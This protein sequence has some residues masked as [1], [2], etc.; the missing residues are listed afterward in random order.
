MTAIVGVATG[1]AVRV[2]GRMRSQFHAP[3]NNQLKVAVE[4]NGGNTYCNIDS[5]NKNDNNAISCGG[6][7]NGSDHNGH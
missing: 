5:D 7:S 2:G 4:K 3:E 1:A 6:G